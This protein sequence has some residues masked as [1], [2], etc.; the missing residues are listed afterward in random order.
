MLDISFIR[1][2]PNLVKENL[3]KRGYTE[4]LK[5]VD[6]VLGLDS[7]WRDRKGKLDVLRHRRNAISLEVSRLKKEGKNVAGLVKETKDLPQKISDAEAKA[8]VLQKK[9]RGYLMLLPN[10]LHDSV[11]VGK[12][13][14]D[15][16]EIKQFG[17]KPRLSFEPKGHVE[18][19]ESLNLVEL[20]RAAK[21]SG[22]RWYFL[23]GKLA[24]LELAL[25]RYAIDFMLKKKYSFVVPPFAMRREAYEGVTSLDAF[26]EMLYK[27]ENDD[28]YLIATS[29]H[30]LTAQYMNEVIDFKE[31]PIK[32]VGFSTN[33]R[34][35][36]GA[37]GKDTK[38]IFRVHQFNK[39]EQII[40][41][42]PEESWH[43]HEELL[44]NAMQFFESLGLHGRVVNVCT[45]DIGI[46]AG[47][48]YDVEIWMPAQKTYRE[49][50]SC[51]NCTSYQAVRLNIRYEKQGKRDYAHTLNSTCV[52][53][54]RAL[55]AILENFQ[56]KDG[57]VIVPK[58]LQRYAGFKEIKKEIKSEKNG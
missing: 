24:L 3:K 22:A 30:P 10:M 15:N 1:Q 58:V 45:G 34:K 21:I 31:L 56:E 54:S 36:A 23:K 46:V 44:R 20:E 5:W 18:L 43:L 13:E 41:C 17:K 40:I 2:F 6:D 48:K 47:K 11:P 53:T 9:I 14:N 27:I 37:H 32:L 51:S 39:V 7:E 38:G 35:E 50:A 12:D 52:A 57:T 26:E 28:L 4:R 49:A 19:M 29:E 25:A 55:A 16:A 8:D 42:R 33:F